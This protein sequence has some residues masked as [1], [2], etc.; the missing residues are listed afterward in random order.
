[1]HG[2]L[3]ARLTMITRLKQFTVSCRPGLTMGEKYA[4]PYVE[5]VESPQGCSI[6]SQAAYYFPHSRPLETVSYYQHCFFTSPQ[7]GT[8]VSPCFPGRQGPACYGLG[9]LLRLLLLLPCATAFLQ[10]QGILAPVS[11][12]QRPC[13]HTCAASSLSSSIATPGP[14][15]YTEGSLPSPPPTFQVTAV[16]PLPPSLPSMTPGSDY[17][18]SQPAR[19]AP[20][21]RKWPV[22]GNMLQLLRSGGFDKFDRFMQGQSWRGSENV[23]MYACMCPDR[24]IT[25]VHASKYTQCQV[26][27]DVVGLGA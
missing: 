25:R 17:Q 5:T 7:I 14:R 15:N 22:F 20:G 19:E 13:L 9:E 16:S 3:R 4:L 26:C 23:Y 21:P 10:P 2:P 11:R 18:I 12:L 1:M 27:L 8:M 24:N 6:C